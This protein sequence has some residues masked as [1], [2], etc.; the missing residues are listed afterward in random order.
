[1][2]TFAVVLSHAQPVSPRA[3]RRTTVAACPLRWCC[4]VQ[5]LMGPPAHCMQDNGRGMS[6]KELSQW[7]VMNLSMEDRGMMAPE[8][9]RAVESSGGAWAFCVYV[10]V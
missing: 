2:Q 10:P 8:G 7:A 4:R 3:H 6:P 1:M 9:Q 5:D